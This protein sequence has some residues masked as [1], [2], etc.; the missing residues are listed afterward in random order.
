MPETSEMQQNQ[1]RKIL[2]PVVGI[3]FRLG[4]LVGRKALSTNA[5]LE[6]L[7]ILERESLLERVPEKLGKADLLP[8]PAKPKL[9]VAQSIDPLEQRES[10]ALLPVTAVPEGYL[11][12]TKLVPFFHREVLRSFYVAN[13]RPKTDRPAK[14]EYSDKTLALAVKELAARAGVTAQDPSLARTIALT[15]AVE[16]E[17][18][19]VPKDVGSSVVYSPEAR[20]KMEAVLRTWVITRVE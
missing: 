8:A 9:P 20:K 5:A 10:T 3:V 11:S 12:A 15:K 17:G 2:S 1:A 19:V 13:C 16:V 7:R 6:V 4:E 14:A 18:K